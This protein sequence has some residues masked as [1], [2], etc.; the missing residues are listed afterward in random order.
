MYLSDTSVQVAVV[1]G[2]KIVSVFLS[3]SLSFSAEAP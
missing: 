2:D 1:Q 3:E